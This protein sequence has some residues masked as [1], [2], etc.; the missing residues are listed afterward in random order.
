MKTEVI[1][2]LLKEAGVSEDKMKAVVDGVMAENGKDIAAEQ[3]KTFAKEGEL[4]TANETIKN[5]QETVKKFDGK[6]PDKLSSDLKAMQDKYDKDI[7]DLKLGSAIDIAIANSKAK[8]VKAIKALL[9]MDSIKL[10]DDKLS[11]FDEQITK[12]KESDAYLF[13]NSGEKQ[14][15]EGKPAGRVKTGSEHGGTPGSEVG[16]DFMAGVRSG[17]GLP[18]VKE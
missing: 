9:D 3:T 5:L 1:E 10:N 13:E 18:E 16:A 11:G 8:N 15:M 4:K 14:S 6:D 7:S 17:A 12:L 2:K